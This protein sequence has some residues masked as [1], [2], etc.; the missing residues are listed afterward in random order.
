MH[1]FMNNYYA[2]V[3][4]SLFTDD[5][6]AAFIVCFHVVNG[7][8]F[9]KMSTFCLSVYLYIYSYIFSLPGLCVQS[10]PCLLNRS[11][12]W[13]FA[14]A[15]GRVVGLLSPISS[16]SPPRKSALAFFCFLRAFRLKPW[17]L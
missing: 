5:Y 9:Q 11:I 3:I 4:V 10:N 8:C 2:I 1:L 14:E 17:S 16:P 12:L 6:K 13:G 15:E 7:F